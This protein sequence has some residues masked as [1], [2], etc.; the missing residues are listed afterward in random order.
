MR[1]EWAW[2]CIQLTNLHNLSVASCNLHSIWFLRCL[3]TLALVSLGCLH[4]SGCV[5]CFKFYA[6]HPTFL[7]V[8]NIWENIRMRNAEFGPTDGL[9]CTFIIKVTTRENLS[10]TLYNSLKLYFFHS[11]MTI[12]DEISIR[13]RIRKSNEFGPIFTHIVG[14]E[15]IWN[16]M[17]EYLSLISLQTTEQT[18]QNFDSLKYILTLS[19]KIYENI[20]KKLCSPWS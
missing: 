19:W 15:K 4:S 11:Q 6:I 1:T 8:E 14:E 16:R 17:L 10:T 12:K 3:N 5:W 18:T 2:R 20:E 9:L 7:A 13:H